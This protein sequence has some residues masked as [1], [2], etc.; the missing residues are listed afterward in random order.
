MED[1]TGSDRLYGPYRLVGCLGRGGVA[2]VYKAVHQLNNT[3]VA[4]K[5]FPSDEMEFPEYV[6]RARRDV[7]AL[8]QCAHPNLVRVLE[9]ALGGQNGYLAVEYVEGRNLRDLVR[10][11]GPMSVDKVLA[12]A[13][14]IAGALAH[15]HARGLIHRD[16][17]PA[18]IM[19]EDGTNRTVLL[20]FGIIKPLN[21]RGQAPTE[22][23]IAESLTYTTPEQFSNR[24]IDG[25]A[26]LYQ[27]GLVIYM[28]V[29]GR[30][31]VP[32]SSLMEGSSRSKRLAGAV[33]LKEASPTSPEGLDVIVSNCS[34]IDPGRRYHAVSDLLDDLD[35]IARGEPVVPRPSQR[36][37]E[38]IQA[39]SPQGARTRTIPAL[40]PP[41][42]GQ[43][44]APV[45]RFVR[46]SRSLMLAL[47]VL[48]IVLVSLWILR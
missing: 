3:T 36:V 18:N 41:A 21:P 24:D 26:D 47:L 35:R 29:T 45:L 38:K 23:S 19:I 20:D 9:C 6:R 30:D 16:V 8:Q 46:I 17:K 44:L 32:I 34:Q 40:Q 42:P 25:R 33:C 4:L 31:P 2:T 27:L 37:T 7:H 14:D 15:C 28:M 48:V 1:P 12:V 43:A 10:E 5:V 22:E 11:S 13:R 39:L